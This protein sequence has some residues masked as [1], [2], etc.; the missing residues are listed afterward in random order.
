MKIE[1][2]LSSLERID[3]ILV[4]AMSDEFASKFSEGDKLSG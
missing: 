2:N 3:H 4:L 1:S